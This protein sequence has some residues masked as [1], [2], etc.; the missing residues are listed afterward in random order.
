[1][2]KTFLLTSLLVISIALPAQ[3]KYS[4]DD[5]WRDAQ[6]KELKQK[7]PVAQQRSQWFR[8]ARLGMFIHWNMSSVVC[9]EISWSK[10]F[11]EDDGEHLHKNPRPTLPDCKEQEHSGW[12]KWFKPAVPKEI[13][14]NLYKSFYPG[15]YNADSIVNTA[16]AAG[17]KYIV[18]VAKH[19]DGFCMWDSKYTDY[20]IMATP[21]HRDLLGEMAA[22]CHQKGMKFFIYYS[23]R[24][25]HHPDY[26]SARIGKY[27]E[28]MRNQ[29]SE[30]LTKYAPVDGI[31]FDAE[32]WN[33]DSTVWEPERLFKTIYAIN[34][35]IIINNRCYAAGDYYTPEQKIGAIDM[36]NTWESCM[37]FTG[38]WSWHGFTS[39]VI[40]T[41]KCLDYLIACAGGNGNLLMDVGPLPTGQI[42]PREKNRLLEIGKWL[43]SNGEA[44][45]S[46]QGGP[47]KPAKWGTCTRKGKDMYL[48]INDWSQF[49]ESLPKMKFKIK[50]VS[51]HGNLID[52]KTNKEGRTT[53]TIP[54][55]MKDQYVTVI[56]IETSK[57]LTGADL[58]D[59]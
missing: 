28:Y 7:S 39:T 4:L 32:A 21:F 15:M 58:I 30:L 20:D 41:Q 48:L 26:T 50:S 40:P 6:I 3:N 19:H 34:P 25:W 9:G 8:N 43:K 38:F 14:D 54:D 42:D 49:P 22:A 23:Q 31:F 18:M 45:Y 16:L 5:A 52:F 24:D 11:Y 47:I 12:L 59:L 51:I 36:D 44:I 27:N 57:D 56:R 53:F 10:Q 17:V 37:T 46:T 33:G 2:R 1:M 35:N 55:E 13:Y 29:I